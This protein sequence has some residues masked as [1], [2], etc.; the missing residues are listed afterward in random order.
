M[1]YD[2]IPHER[3][4]VIHND[5]IDT[6]RYIESTSNVADLSIDVFETFE[7]DSSNRSHEPT[8]DLSTNRVLLQQSSILPIFTV[9]LL[10]TTVIVLCRVDR[11]SCSQP[12]MWWSL[13]YVSRHVAKSV[14]Y[15]MA[16]RR[17]NVGGSVPPK[18]ILSLSVVDLAGPIIWTLGGYFIFHT[19]SCST[20]LYAYAVILWSLQSIS[21]LL[22]CC[23]V[24]VIL[25]CAPCLLWLA[26]FVIRPNPNTVATS[27]DVLM[28]VP[29]VP[30]SSLSNASD[31]QCC[32]ICLADYRPDEE[33]MKLSCSHFFHSDCISQWACLSQLCPVC[34]AQIAALATDVSH[35]SV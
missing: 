26:P 13:A 10:I 11:N 17:T 31:S 24:S 5:E 34:R 7:S 28:K 1:R 32:T 30:F 25:F 19:E 27:R 9:V 33:V 21:L 8:T 16:W 4:N 6:I 14:L 22:P 20:G 2:R 23:F 3:E 12:L 15:R 18:L 35:E 29:R